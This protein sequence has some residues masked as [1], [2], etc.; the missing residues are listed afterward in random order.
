[1]R[2]FAHDPPTF[3][4]LR[5]KIGRGEQ[6]RLFIAAAGTILGAPNPYVYPDNLPRV[7]ATVDEADGLL[8]DDHPG[9][10]PAPIW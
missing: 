3:T 10:W 6:Q 1:M 8:A 4:T 9:S 5:P 2:R 7:N